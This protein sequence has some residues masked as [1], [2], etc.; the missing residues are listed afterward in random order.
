MKNV[1]IITGGSRGIGAAT[2]VLLSK[3]GVDVCLCYQSDQASADAVVAACQAEGVRACAFQA[4]VANITDVQKLFAFCDA[5][6]G[7]ANILI[8]NA[9]IVGEASKLVDLQPEVLE[10]VFAVNLFGAIYC[11]QEA[12]KRMA[13]SFGGSGGCIVNISSMAA[14]FGSPNEYIHYAASKGALDSMTIGLAKEVGPEGI[15]V[16]AIHS[17]TA[18]TDIHQRTGNPGRPA[19]VASINPLGRVARPEEIA[20]AALW[21]ALDKSS[22]TNGAIMPV[23]GGM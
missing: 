11:C 2:A 3:S 17:G 14:K 20:E 19:M 8:N 12:I 21:L 6:L 1:A 7:A 15:R 10:R 13:K 5:Q 22:Y 18:D 23:T 4:D 16:N 9:G